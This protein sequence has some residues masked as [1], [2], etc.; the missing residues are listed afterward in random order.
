MRKKNKAGKNKIIF[1]SDLADGIEKAVSEAASFLEKNQLDDGSFLSFSSEDLGDFSKVKEYHSIF[2]S[3]LILSSLAAVKTRG[4]AKKKIIGR[5]KKG[6]AN[7]LLSQ[8]SD[9]W[10]FNYWK[11]DSEESG[12][13]PYPDDLDDTFC[14][15]SALFLC[16][17]SIFGGD[18]LAKIVALL[19]STE[20]KEGGP[21]QTWLV[22]GNA[23]PV[24][25][26]VDLAVNSNVA[27]FLSLQE[28]EL[29]NLENFVEKAIMVDKLISPY[30]PNFYPLVYFI[31]RFYK[32]RLKN[33]LID[34]I[35]LNRKNGIWENS[36]YTSL[37]ISA[38]LNLGYS[39]GK[40][41]EAVE[42]LLSCQQ[43]GGWGACAFCLDP[44][45]GGKVFYCGSDALT[46]AFC[47][48]ALEKYKEKINLEKK[49][50]GAFVGEILNRKL[51][52]Q[53]KIQSL[54]IEKYREKFSYLGEDLN[55][56]SE[57]ALKKILKIDERDRQ[58]TLLP[59]LFKKSL[60]RGNEI[61]SDLA[62][63]LGFANLLGWT[64]YT[65]YDDFL[66]LEGDSKMLSV[67]NVALRELAL[68]F[69][70]LDI[71]GVKDFF[72]K[73]MDKIDSANG[74]E[75]SKCK[76]ENFVFS[77]REN[78]FG[79]YSI[80][81]EK[82]LGHCLGCVAILLKLGF[83]ENSSEIKKLMDFFS[84]F[85]IARQLHDDAHD[86]EDDLRRGYVNSASA[87]TLNEAGKARGKKENQKKIDLKKDL[88][89]LQEIF[90]E[91]TIIQIC[92]LVL[93]HLKEAEICLSELTCLEDI[94]IFKD[95]LANLKNSAKKTLR[96]QKDVKNFLNNF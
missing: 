61:S 14:A 52:E 19:A 44:A 36:L 95:F 37:A 75:V 29:P 90:W 10:S 21:Y 84:H 57:I 6:I 22:C 34:F 25:K 46:T 50:A 26:D 28:V 39:F 7:F 31:S 67:A 3:S 32:G 77:E 4:F 92:K 53:L 86:W 38:L 5:V 83:K 64:A 30:Y 63:Q 40:L 80:L 96:Q 13:M 74:Q 93:A 89:H 12:G 55:K 47:V 94:S 87:L 49:Q 54:I 76:L 17:S 41:K 62:I 68:I 88:K 71:S 45:I 11:R 23:D 59:Y 16:K 33:R 51:E 69:G 85:L 1:G 9:C 91:N 65:I 20:K 79:D 72:T 43:N 18:V 27:Y 8:K 2:S 78:V 48:E 42:Y 82:S 81:A 66:D 60:K 35:L 70:S 56:Q 24:W 15:L 58:I 73:I